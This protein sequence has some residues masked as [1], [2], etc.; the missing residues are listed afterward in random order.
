MLPFSAAD[1]RRRLSADPQLADAH[2][3]LGLSLALQGEAATAIRLLRRVPWL[4]PSRLDALIT[5]GVALLEAG[6]FAEAAT[7]FHKV[8]GHAPSDPDALQGLGLV[9]DQLQPGGDLRHLRRASKVRPLD[10]ETMRNLAAA[11]DHRGCLLEAITLLRRAAALSPESAIVH[12]DLG[13]SLGKLSWRTASWTASLRAATIEPGSS[14]A[15][16]HAAAALASAG[17]HVRA[18]ACLD[19]AID[20]SPTE[21]TPF[22]RKLAAMCYVPDFNEARQWSV[23]QEFARRFAPASPFRPFTN[24]P[25]PERR[26]R[27]GYLSANFHNHP[28]AHYLIPLLAERNRAGTEVYCYAETAH[29]D[30]MTARLTEQADHWRRTNDLSDAEVARSIR[31]DEI[32]ILVVLGGRFERNRLLVA[33]HRAAPVQI[34]LHD[35]GTSGLGTMTYLIADRVMVEPVSRRRERFS[36]RVLRLPSLHIF[37]RPDAT[38]NISPPPVLEAGRI[39]FGSFNNPMKV[40]DRVLAAWGRI[41][42]A[43][44]YSRLILKY[45]D[46]YEDPDLKARI[47]GRLGVGSDRVEFVSRIDSPVDH[48]RSYARVD[49]ALDTFPFNGET[50]TWNALWMGLP[51]VTLSGETLVGRLSASLL[52][53]IGLDGLIAR[54]SD[55]YVEIARRLASDRNRLTELRATMRDRLERS[56]VC[57]AR[58]RARQMDRLYRWVW[59]RWCRDNAAGLPSSDRTNRR[60]AP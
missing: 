6:R 44:P 7:T 48:L 3:H 28:I 42:A 25:Q 39:T 20:R 46:L 30:A 15:L 53:P 57:D 16:I 13:A 59:R 21:P 5:L 38:P 47:H 24:Q 37:E 10:V 32:D 49:I 35:A 14:T 41:L 50:T 54:D 34:S 56:P 22:R 43:V 2:H 51:V 36:E 4:T 19:R 23:S 26:L 55:G 17:A 8:L 9:L 52:R 45:I 27:I 1:L 18:L 33:A 58:A 40:N 31:A 29:R 60:A 12:L 11:L